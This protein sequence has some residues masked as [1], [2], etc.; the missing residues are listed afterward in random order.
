MI[1]WIILGVVVV[2]IVGAVVGLIVYKNNKDKISRATAEAGQ[3]IS[4]IKK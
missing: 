2:F 1:G 3:V 4:D